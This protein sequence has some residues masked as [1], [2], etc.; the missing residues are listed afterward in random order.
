MIEIEASTG[1]DGIKT[2]LENLSSHYKISLKI[3]LPQIVI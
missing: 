2:G 1:L 3:E